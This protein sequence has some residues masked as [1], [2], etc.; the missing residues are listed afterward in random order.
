MLGV[1]LKAP[2]SRAPADVVLKLTLPPGVVLKEAR[3]KGARRHGAGNSLNQRGANLYFSDVL[4]PGVTAS[5][6]VMKVLVD[7]CPPAALSFGIATYVGNNG[8][9]YTTYP[10]KILAVKSGFKRCR[11]S[12]APTPAPATSA[13]GYTPFAEG[14]VCE[15]S[16]LQVDSLGR[17]VDAALVHVN[18]YESSEACY[19]HCSLTYGPPS[20]TYFSW[21]AATNACYCC[22]KETCNL[23]SVEDRQTTTFQVSTL[24]TNSP[25]ALPSVSP[26]QVPTQLPSQLP[27]QQPTMLPTMLPSM[28]P[29]QLPSQ[30]PTILP[31]LLPTQMPTMAPTMVRSQM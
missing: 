31:S 8:S 16:E 20:T 18:S 21:S 25:T 29:T 3:Q 24:A 6:V 2:T 30:Q 12:P 5:H 1:K 14:Q 26:T 22:N 11:P 10:P 13:S 19:T 7:A 4:G 27:S 28:L 9:C 23:L 17:V 15:G